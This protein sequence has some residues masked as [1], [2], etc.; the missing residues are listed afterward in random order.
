MAQIQNRTIYTADNLAVLRGLPQGV[1]DLIYLDPPFNSKKQWANPLKT[2]DADKKIIGKF[3]DTW[4][5]SDIND[6]DRLSMIRYG[7]S[8]VVSVIDTLAEVNGDEWRNYLIYMGVRLV[9]MRR[10]LKDTGSIYLHC[11]P[12]MNA[13]LKLLMDAVFGNKQFRNEIVW[14]RATKPKHSPKSFGAFTDHIL[15]Y[16]KGKRA[17]F[18]PVKLPSNTE[19]MKRFR[20]T[21]E[22]TGR[23][24]YLRSLD[25][26]RRD[27]RKGKVLVFR[28]KEYTPKNSWQWSQETL[29]ARLAEN[30]HVVQVKNGTLHFRQYADGEPITNLWD[31]IAPPPPEESTGYPTEKPMELLRRIIKASSKRGD[32]VL[33]PFCG[34]ATTCVAAEE[35]GREWVG[36]DIGKEAVDFVLAKLRK[37]TEAG[38][39]LWNPVEAPVHH[40]NVFEGD[41]LPR[42][43]QAYDKE[44]VS[45]KLYRDQNKIC[46]VCDE[47]VKARLMHID[48][49]T[50]K[51][52]GGRDEIENFQLLCSDCNQRKGIKTTAEAR[53]NAM[54]KRVAEE[55]DAW[56]KKREIKIQKEAARR[57]KQADRAAKKK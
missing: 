19:S 11:D 2:D 10:V 47:S 57:Q 20:R 53:R 31:N 52:R 13:G 39:V 3:K 24:Y 34:C 4:Y 49:I 8:A 32:I 29:D 45:A 5:A 36:I 26:N 17:S 18:Y 55:M 16:M 41:K 40:I 1:V 46:A 43:K 54:A 21:E 50:P 37:A 6:D 23:R 44:A 12:T 25:I 42:I 51:A 35:L 56:K 33:D 30:P 7:Y 9:E 38:R 14:R 22:E 48:H 27:N 15:F 28:G